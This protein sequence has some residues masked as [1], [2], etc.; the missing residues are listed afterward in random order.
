M[1]KNV[2]SIIL[3]ILK[4]IRLNKTLNWTVCDT[5]KLSIK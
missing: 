3:I 2:Y 5:N 4:D 1:N